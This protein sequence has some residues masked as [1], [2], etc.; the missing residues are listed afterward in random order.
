M[1]CTSLGKTN[2]MFTMGESEI[3]KAGNFIAAAEDLLGLDLTKSLNQGKGRA[4][5]SSVI[6]ENPRAT[7]Q[8]DTVI[9]LASF[10]KTRLT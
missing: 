5:I 9:I 4:V 6:Q 1:L 10:I 7:A 3:K 2:V 8:V